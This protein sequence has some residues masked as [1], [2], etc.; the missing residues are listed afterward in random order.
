VSSSDQQSQGQSEND[1]G[2]LED[3]SYDPDSDSSSDSEDGYDDQDDQ[4]LDDSS[5]DD[6]GG[7]NLV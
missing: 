1:S 5:F 2:Q 3:A 4:Q 6:G 7:D